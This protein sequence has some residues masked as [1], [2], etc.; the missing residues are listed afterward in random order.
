MYL[1]PRRLSVLLTLPFLL[2]TI[3]P[4]EA[5]PPGDDPGAPRHPGP[6]P[7]YRLAVANPG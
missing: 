1:T 3:V 7:L 6:A 2:T 4:V 5:E